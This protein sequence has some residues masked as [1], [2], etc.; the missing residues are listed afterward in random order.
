[1]YVG[2]SAVLKR[3]CVLLPRRVIF[4]IK[5]TE[6]PLLVPLDLGDCSVECKAR[7]VLKQKKIVQSFE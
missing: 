6:A 1:L 4:D 5:E 3:E 7:V 2:V